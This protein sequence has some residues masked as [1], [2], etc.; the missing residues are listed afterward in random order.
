MTTIRRRPEPGRPVRSAVLAAALASAY[1]APS[2]GADWVVVP[3]F[4]VDQLYSDNVG[5]NVDGAREEDFVTSV[6]SGV[7]IRGTGRR[8]TFALDYNA[9]ALVYQRDHDRNGIQQQFQLDADAELYERV[10]FLEVSGKR[11]QQ[12]A[13]NQVASGT[14][15][16]SGS[17]NTR[18][19]VQTYTIAPIVR[20]RLGSYADIESRFELNQVSNERNSV[21]NT[22]VSRRSTVTIDSGDR[23]ARVPWSLNY[24]NT[25]TRT[26]SGEVQ[27]FERAGAEA[28]IQINRKYAMLARVGVENNEFTSNQNA[29]DGATWDLGFTWTP[30]R[31]TTLEVGYG[32]RFFDRNF[33]FDL[34]HRTKKLTIAASYS[35][36]ITTSREEQL[37]RVLVPLTDAAGNAVLDPVS[38]AQIQVPIDNLEIS[39]EVIAE[40]RF[41]GSIAYTG[42]R[43]TAT[44][45]G[46][47]SERS[48]QQTNSDSSV[49]GAS[50]AVQRRLSRNTT[51]SGTASTQFTENGGQDSERY[52][53]NLDLVHTLSGTWQTNVRLAHVTQ[54][55]D[56]ASNEFHENRVS[57]GMVATF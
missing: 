38:G 43:T 31:R 22:S 51:L 24:S 37:N 54:E 14:D 28:R 48:G 35:Q 50:L 6:E 19:D 20:H 33:F 25:R 12:N 13:S 30:S 46:F 41:D 8:L 27:R 32:S 57:V 49:Y 10:L 16:I 40:Q 34:S 56:N 1:A 52:S 4:S 26:S 42:R 17:D 2:A 44:L 36:D 11:S 5:L 9:E 55:S 45:S 15:N 47:G 21:R 53:F 7:L 29:R 23:F 18:V 3:R 39:D